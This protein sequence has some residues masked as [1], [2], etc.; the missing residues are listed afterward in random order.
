MATVS[1]I[2]VNIAADAAAHVRQL[3]MQP[4]FEIML[5][6]LRDIIPGIRAI[7]VTLEYPSEYVDDPTI[8]LTTYQPRSPGTGDPTRSAWCSWSSTFSPDVLKHFVRLPFY[9]EGNGR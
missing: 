2:P 1:T 6:R 7:D 3:G 8:L 9:G 5:E 4:Q